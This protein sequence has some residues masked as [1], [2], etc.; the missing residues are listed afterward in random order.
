MNK[1]KALAEYLTV[2]FALVGSCYTLYLA[3]ALMRNAGSIP[4]HQAM[5]L[6]IIAFYLLIIAI[7]QIYD[8]V[9][10]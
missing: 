8:I 7:K 3:A 6:M 1:L 4:D 10:H 9:K 2:L 5:A